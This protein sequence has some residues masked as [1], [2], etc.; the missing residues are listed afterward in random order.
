MSINSG[1]IPVPEPIKAQSC[2]FELK[3]RLGFDESALTTVDVT[4]E[5]AFN[6]SQIAGALSVP[7]DQLS[8]IKSEMPSLGK[9]PKDE[10][11][12]FD[13]PAL[14]AFLLV[15]EKLY[16]LLVLLQASKLSRVPTATARLTLATRLTSKQQQLLVY[17]TLDVRLRVYW[18]NDSYKLS[19][20]EIEQRTIIIGGSYL[21]SWQIWLSVSIMVDAT[22]LGFLA[23]VTCQCHCCFLAN[24]QDFPELVGGLAA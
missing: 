18:R 11:S 24:Y 4:S 10:K 9:A 17:E 16:Y 19:R 3:R 1:L 6:A 23:V 20:E 14:S 2:A 21:D 22:N 15:A 12:R 8:L 5:E 7:L 13:D